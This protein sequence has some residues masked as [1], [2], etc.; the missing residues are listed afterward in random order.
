LKWL[1]D[2]INVVKPGATTSDV[3]KVRPAPEELGL[4]TEDEA[5]FF[6]SAMVWE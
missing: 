2:S 3:A 5:F 1:E 4:K 6:S